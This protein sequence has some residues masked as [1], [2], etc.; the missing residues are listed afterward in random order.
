MTLMR[1]GG[2]Y[3]APMPT[4]RSGL[5]IAALKEYLFAIGGFDSKSRS[6]AVERYDTTSNTWTRMS[7]MRFCRWGQGRWGQVAGT[8]SVTEVVGSDFDD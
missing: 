3:G 6:V 2:I 4:P 8:V 1:I 5:Q 7:N